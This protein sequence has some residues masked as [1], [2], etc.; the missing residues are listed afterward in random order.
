MSVKD[1]VQNIIPQLFVKRSLRMTT[2]RKVDAIEKSTKGVTTADEA[3][4]E[5]SAA[6]RNRRKKDVPIEPYTVAD[7][8]AVF[9]DLMK[10]RAPSAQYFKTS[11]DGMIGFGAN[12]FEAF[13]S[14]IASNKSDGSLLVLH[15]TASGCERIV[16][17]AILDDFDRVRFIT[18]DVNQNQEAASYR[19]V[20]RVPFFQ[21]CV[22]GKVVDA[23]SGAD[24][25]KLRSALR[26]YSKLVTCTP[27]FSNSYSEEPTFGDPVAHLDDDEDDEEAVLESDHPQ[28]DVSAEKVGELPSHFLEQLE[29]LDLSHGIEKGLMTE[30]KKA[31]IKELIKKTNEANGVTTEHEVG[32]QKKLQ[33]VGKCIAGFEWL[34]VKGGY[35]CAGGS[36]FVSDAKLK[37]FP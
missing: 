32:I 30:E 26:K 34:K 2:A 16:F 17:D 18:I 19:G 8:C 21:L 24:E 25:V 36:H 9:D 14:E 6:S 1:V 13:D 29:A 31:A 33:K 28:P 22:S 4:S 15:F 12:T 37:A 27:S 5:P 35:R 11:E 10:T 23:F 3:P 20:N 7:I